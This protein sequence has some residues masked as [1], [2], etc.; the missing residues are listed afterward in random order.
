MPTLPPRLRARS[1]ALVLLWT[2]LVFGYG[3]AA[4]HYRLFPFALLQKAVHSARGAPEGR[5]GVAREPSADDPLADQLTAL[6]YAGGYETA[7]DAGRV[8]DGGA[9]PAG[10]GFTLYSSGHAPVVQLLSRGG[11]VVHTWTVPID[12][13]WPEPLPFQ[14]APVDRHYIRRAHVFPNGD[15]IG[16]FEYIG[17]FKVDRDSQ[18]LWARLGRHHHDFEVQPDGSIV[19][20]ARV[21]RSRAWLQ[22]RYPG[23]RLSDAGSLFDDAVVVLDAEGQERARVSLLDAL[24]HSDHA[25]LIVRNP[26]KHP[27]EL[28]HAN[29]VYVVKGSEDSPLFTRG[30]VLLSLRDIST[31]VAIDMEAARVVWAM[32]GGFHR[33]HQA[34][35]LPNGHILLFDNQGGNVEQP[36]RLNRSQILE[37]DPVSQR[38][39]WRY[40]GSAR[41][42]FY[43]FY[44]GY[45]ERLESGNTLITESTQGRIFEVDPHGRVCWQFENPHRAGEG[46]R[47][48]ATTMGAKRYAAETLPF[49]GLGK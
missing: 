35:L 41:A 7:R 26:N 22:A 14:A 12:T 46:D 37:L 4:G 38:V 44:M 15:L 39:V 32:G 45:V 8:V 16:V 6:G 47:L 30:Q 11:A 18:V 23:I 36:L 43:S 42:P 25:A 13:L 2:S 49:L 33:Q 17:I 21:E 48:I 10:A 29:S 40:R 24:Y 31:L 34:S 28:F 20:L 3:L 27:L 1:V 9:S 19:A 5:F